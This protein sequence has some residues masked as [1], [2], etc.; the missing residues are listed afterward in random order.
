[1]AEGAAQG[2]LLI[3]DNNEDSV[4]AQHILRRV[5]NRPIIHCPDGESA[6]DYLSRRGAP[7]ETPHTPRPALILLDLHLPGIDGYEVLR[8]IKQDIRLRTIPVVV[9]TTSANPHDVDLCYRYGANSYI[10][11][12]V[13]FER[14][15]HSL[16][17]LTAYWFEVVT[18][19]EGR[20]A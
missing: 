5:T 14:L 18:L 11:K 3:E 2:I 8:Q 12:S 7:A 13:D 16:E 19:S 6:L 9:L 20:S 10:V 17:R 15:R 1:M 4:V